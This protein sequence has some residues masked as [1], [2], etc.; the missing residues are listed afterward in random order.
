MKPA[1][2]WDGTNGLR[3]ITD[4]CDRLAVVGVDGR[5]GIH[6]PPSRPAETTCIGGPEC[7]CSGCAQ[8]GPSLA[9][10]VNG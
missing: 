6:A 8:P 7:R 9:D 10:I 3:C 4:G 2:K 1:P 5:C